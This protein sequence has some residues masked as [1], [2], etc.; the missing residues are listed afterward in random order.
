MRCSY[1]TRSGFSIIEAVMVLTIVLVVVGSLMPTT[2]GILSRSRINRAANV[3]AA[4]FYLAQTQASRLRVPVTITLNTSTRILRITTSNDTLLTRYYGSESDFN[5][6]SVTA[7]PA[8]IIVLPSGMTSAQ[9]TLTL[10]NGTYQRRVRISRAGQIR[11][12]LN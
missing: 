1:S 4:D 12:L 8:S 6:S 2:Q 3:G 9:M 10:S 7:S 5:V 11:I